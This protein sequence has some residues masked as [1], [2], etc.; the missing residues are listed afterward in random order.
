MVRSKVNVLRYLNAFGSY[1]LP[2]LVIGN[3]FFSAW[4]WNRI[5]YNYVYSCIFLFLSN[6]L[7]KGL[8]ECLGEKKGWI[9]MW[10]RNTSDSGFLYYSQ[11]T[12]Y[13][14]LLSSE[15]SLYLFKLCV[16]IPWD[17]KME[18][19]KNHSCCG[20]VNLTTISLSNKFIYFHD[21]SFFLST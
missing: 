9:Y 3:H 11:C 13:N 15:L 18:F 19:H 8:G 7:K 4:G 20:L 12:R 6:S 2:M 10:F 21:S 17:T 5:L 1:M 14:Q 16:C